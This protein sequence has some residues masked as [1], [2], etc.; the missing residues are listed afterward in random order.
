MDSFLSLFDPNDNV[1]DCPACP[2]DDFSVC[3]QLPPEPQLGNIEYKLKLVNPSKLRFQHLVT[4]VSLI[5]DQ[6]VVAL[7]VAAHFGCSR[8]VVYP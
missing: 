8:A 3:T 6:T 7:R 2:A 5:K 4:Q 1:E